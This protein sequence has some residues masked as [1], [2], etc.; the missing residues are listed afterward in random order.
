M[1]TSNTPAGDPLVHCQLMRGLGLLI[2]LGAA[3]C[4]GELTETA[5]TTLDVRP[6]AAVTLQN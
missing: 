4:S 3:A 5:P 1:T 6:F 2:V